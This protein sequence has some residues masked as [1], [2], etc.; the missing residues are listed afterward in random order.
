MALLS[1]LNYVSDKVKQCHVIRYHLV[2]EQGEETSNKSIAIA[3]RQFD[4]EMER[5][6][7]QKTVAEPQIS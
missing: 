7:L 5:K 4:R 1:D 6:E 3:V 2:G